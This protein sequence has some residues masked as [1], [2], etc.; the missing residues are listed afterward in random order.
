MPECPQNKSPATALPL[1]FGVGF[2]A[3]DFWEIPTCTNQVGLQL[4]T[5]FTQDSGSRTTGA[6]WILQS[7]V[8]KP[9]KVVRVCLLACACKCLCRTAPYRPYTSHPNPHN[10]LIMQNP[11]PAL[12]HLWTSIFAYE[13][14][15][16]CLGMDRTRKLWKEYEPHS[17]PY[18]L[19]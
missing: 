11:V 1:N 17:Q 9:V 8:C 2:G 7:W 6:T 3:P 14:R 4:E 18:L 12:T 16:V 13:L 10:T 15:S 19:D 5:V